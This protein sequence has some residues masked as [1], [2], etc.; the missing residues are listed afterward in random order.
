MSDLALKATLDTTAVDRSLAHISVG[1]KSFADGAVKEFA[2]IE[3]AQKSLEKSATTSTRGSGAVRGG[4]GGSRNASYIAGQA[5][6]QAQDIAVQLQMG[7]KASTV[8]AQQG[9]QL[10]SLFG[11]G[12]MLVG[13]ALAVG[14]AIFSWVTNTE[15]AE[16]AAQKLEEQIKKTKVANDALYKSRLGDEDVTSDIRT[17]RMLGKSVLKEKRLER[18]YE[19]EIADIKNN[20][21]TTPIAK[22]DALESAKKRYDAERELMIEERKQALIDANQKEIE[23]READVNKVNAD[24]QKGQ[25]E[26]R[27]KTEE[28]IAKIKAKSD[29]TAA[30]NQE[31]LN[32]ANIKWQE[33][34]MANWN[35]QQAKLEQRAKGFEQLSKMLRTEQENANASVAAMAAQ[36]FDEL[37]GATFGKSQSDIRKQLR[38]DASAQKKDAAWEKKMTETGGLVDIK[39]GMDGKIISGRDPIT[40]KRVSGKEAQERF[41]ALQAGK[42]IDENKN[43]LDLSDASVTKLTTA[44]KN[45]LPL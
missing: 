41:R 8:I 16:K 2:R 34:Y 39:R 23:Q 31:A 29:E 33:D 18:D 35:I 38:A 21:D 25:D 9:S 40:G 3:K 22:R 37:K 6:M 12:G 20:K 17:E 26:Q 7:A 1:T 5:A 13:G 15:A 42:M 43:K 28:E 4:F 24:W 19:R 14:A 10:L 11:P 30:K 32:A 27:I 44:I 45:L 36:K